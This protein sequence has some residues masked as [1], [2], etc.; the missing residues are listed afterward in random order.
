MGPC[1][2]E[3]SLASTRSNSDAEGPGHP[4]RNALPLLLVKTPLYGE[5]Q[6]Q[7]AVTRQAL[8]EPHSGGGSYPTQ[9]GDTPEHDVPGCP[10]ES[11]WLRGKM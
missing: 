1:N 11:S 7:G 2:R 9:A 4:Q 8:L 10:P 6:V 3:T 5:Q